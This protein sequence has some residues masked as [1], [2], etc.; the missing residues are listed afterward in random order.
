MSNIAF[1]KIGT[2]SQDPTTLSQDEA[3]IARKM[4][5]YEW[6]D[7]DMTEA[8]LDESSEVQSSQSQ[9]S[10]SQKATTSKLPEKRKR[11]N[12]KYTQRKKPKKP[13][14]TE[15]SDIMDISSSDDESPVHTVRKSRKAYFDSSSSDEEMNFVQQAELAILKR[16]Q[17]QSGMSAET[18]ENGEDNT[19]EFV[20]PDENAG[21]K[22]W[23]IYKKN[24][25]K[26]YK[27]NSKGKLVVDSGMHN[28]D[29]IVNLS[30]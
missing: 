30:S 10:S 22:K 12:I 2:P 26:T 27:R 20:T 24:P 6:S 29:I 1:H 19:T 14:V 13:E 17:Q 25:P 23:E 16:Q 21:K 5:N 9:R 4:K 28:C 18:S 8:S 11:D 3:D 15:S 7:L